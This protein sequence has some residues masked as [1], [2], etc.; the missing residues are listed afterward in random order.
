MANYTIPLSYVLSATAVPASRG[1]Q[2]KQL[3]TILILTDDEPVSTLE[4][5]YI[6][7]RTHHQ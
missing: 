6:I 4:G 5:S 3:G 7:S 1:L 2:P